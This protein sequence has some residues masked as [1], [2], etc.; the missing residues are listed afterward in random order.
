[1]TQ[2]EVLKIEKSLSKIDKGSFCYTILFKD[3]STGKSLK[4]Y[5][6]EKY[7]GQPSRNYPYWLPVL[8]KGIGTIIRNFIYLIG[9]PD[10]IDADSR[11]SLGL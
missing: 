3:L 2:A 9:K 10:Y 5:V 6:S 4:T 7:K 1:M 8:K 11:F